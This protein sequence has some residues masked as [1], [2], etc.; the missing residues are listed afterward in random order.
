MSAWIVKKIEDTMV[1]VIEA[2]KATE[3]ETHGPISENLQRPTHDFGFEGRLDLPVGDLL[4]VDP[5]EEL[6]ALDVLL[7]LLPASK[8]L[9]RVLD[10]KLKR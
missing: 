3:G 6:V 1:H 7:A 4:P 9:R 8:T 10:Q 5:P 2:S